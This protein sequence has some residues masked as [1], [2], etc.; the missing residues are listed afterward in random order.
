[1]RGKMFF[2]FCKNIFEATHERTWRHLKQRRKEDVSYPMGWLSFMSF[3][4]NLYNILFF[5]QIAVDEI[6]E[7]T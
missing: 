1:M 2:F 4:K 6:Q 5:I 3:R 7:E